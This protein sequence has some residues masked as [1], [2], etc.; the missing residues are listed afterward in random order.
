[1]TILNQSILNQLIKLL[2]DDNIKV[3]A[4][5]TTI[6]PAIIIVRFRDSEGDT[7]YVYE[8]DNNAAFERLIG[9]G[10]HVYWNKVSGFL[11]NKDKYKLR[12]DKDKKL[13]SIEVKS[14]SGEWKKLDK[15][16]LPKEVISMLERP[17]FNTKSMIRGR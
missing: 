3:L 2:E 15:D 4:A 11:K 14:E 7:I 17:H 1:M 8:T 6:Y 16:K 13:K 12:F 5:D 10:A 9:N